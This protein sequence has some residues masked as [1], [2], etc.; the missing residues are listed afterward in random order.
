MFKI[1]RLDFISTLLVGFLLLSCKGKS[2]NFE[3]DLSDFKVPNKSSIKISNP[4][5]SDSS[6]SKNRIIKNELI[7]YQD[8]EAVLSSV[9]LGKKD[10][11]SEEKFKIK[12]LTSDLKLTGFLNTKSNKYVFVSYFGKEG[13]ITEES[14][15]GINTTLLPNGAKVIKIDPK[16]L[17]LT[18]NFES[19]D[20]IL[21]LNNL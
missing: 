9:F 17:Q 6:K 16:K 8:K 21:D 15:G 12:N 5:V 3:I 10:P 4:E 13:T 2:E 20:Y 7:N 18:I 14:I 19:K 1:F 11:F